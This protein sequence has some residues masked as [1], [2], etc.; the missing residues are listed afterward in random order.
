[1]I[2]T[3]CVAL[4]AMASLA[5]GQTV[6]AAVMWLK[7]QKETTPSTYV[8]SETADLWHLSRVPGRNDQAEIRRENAPSTW[9]FT[10]NTEIGSVYAERQ[11]VT[12]EVA[13]DKT[14]RIHYQL[15]A[16]WGPKA[17][18]DRAGDLTLSGKGK[19]V[20]QTTSRSQAWGATLVDKTGSRLT[21]DGAMLETGTLSVT[22]AANQVQIRNGAYVHVKDTATI[23]GTL[24]VQ[25]SPDYY[26][27]APLQGKTLVFGEGSQLKLTLADGFVPADNASFK[28]LEF[29]SIKGVPELSLP[30]LPAK[31]AWDTSDFETRGIIRVKATP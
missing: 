12:L 26:L 6:Q 22:N 11:P 18:H 14:V 23:D 2:R 19:F 24:A 28:V 7:D 30:A 13:T 29:T 4:A 17:D 20:V 3:R 10:E 9:K 16:Q 27:S 1:M 25:L 15:A 5:I 21:V 8:W 31:Q